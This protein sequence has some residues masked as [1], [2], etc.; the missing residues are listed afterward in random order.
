MPSN[1][2]SSLPVV[3]PCALRDFTLFDVTGL[4]PDSFFGAL[5]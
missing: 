1:N 3:D 5:A 4:R 2:S